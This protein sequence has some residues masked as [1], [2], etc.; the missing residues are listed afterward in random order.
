MKTVS[1]K[2]R[3]AR[4]EDIERIVE[5]ERSWVH[6]SHWSV[7]AYRRLVNEDSF[8]SSFVAESED[9]DGGFSIVGFVIFHL[10]DNVSEIYN[11]AVDE[12]HSRSGIGTFLMQAVVDSV[13]ADGARKLMLEVRKSNRSAIRFYRRFKFR[14][15]GERTNYY[16]NPIED[17][18]VMERDLRL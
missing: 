10:A 15:V 5:I 3:V 6:L 4:R 2:V 8:T 18:F 1:T 16:S 14:V 17:A 13:R 9:P 7:D 12:T 11:I